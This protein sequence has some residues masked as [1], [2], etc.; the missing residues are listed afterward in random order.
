MNDPSVQ[1]EYSF[2]VIH[3]S[4]AKPT[5]KLVINQYVNKFP[6][7]H[8]SKGQTTQHT[9]NI[10]KMETYQERTEVWDNEGGY[11]SLLPLSPLGHNEI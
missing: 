6:L 4:K 3:Y 10:I 2:N 8:K 5:S 11:M 7:S 1:S 9:Q